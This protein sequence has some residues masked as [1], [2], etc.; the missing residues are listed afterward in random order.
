MVLTEEKKPMSSLNIY[1]T[2]E[3]RERLPKIAEWLEKSGVPNLRDNRG[4]ISISALIRY[5]TDK[6]WSRLEKGLSEALVLSMMLAV[7]NKHLREN[8]VSEQLI[9]EAFR[10]GLAEFHRLMAEAEKGSNDE[11]G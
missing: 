3:H 11:P 1:V 8:G 9:N 7:S 2:D 10:V 6:E 4:N 5:W